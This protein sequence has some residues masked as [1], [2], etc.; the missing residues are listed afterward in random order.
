LDA[1][2]EASLH[3]KV[4]AMDLVYLDPMKDMAQTTI[5]AGVHTMLTFLTGYYVRLSQN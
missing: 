1:V 4:K 2:Y 3:N 5:K